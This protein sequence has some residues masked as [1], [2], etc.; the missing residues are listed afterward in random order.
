VSTGFTAGA[1]Y[2]ALL[3]GT[4]L[5][6]VTGVCVAAASGLA[7]RLERLIATLV[8][9]VAQIVGTLLFAGV[10]LRSLS[11]GTVL[12]VNLIVTA[13]AVALAAR[14]RDFASSF[15]SDWTAVRQPTRRGWRR[16][17]RRNVWAWVLAVVVGVESAYL[18]LVVYVMPSASWDSLTYHLPA[19]A[20]WLQ[21]DRILVTP[22]I[23]L[24]NVYPMNGELGF[25]WV[26]SLTRSD[27]LIDGVPFVF[28]VIGAVAVAA[29]ARSVG[30]S[31]P[32]SFVAASLYLLTPLVL[33][34]ATTNYVDLVL[35]GLYLAGYALLLR[36]LIAE[37]HGITGAP[38]SSDAR[39]A[40]LV[41]AGIALGLAAG[42]KST[43]AMYAAIAVLV[44]LANA[45]WW[46]RRNGLPWRACL[47]RLGVFALPIIAFGSFWYVRTWIEY[48]NPTYPFRVELAGVTVFDGRSP[49]DE[50][51]PPADIA[52]YPPAVR[53]LASWSHISSEYFY[54]ER[55]DG[56]GPT[57]LFLELPALAVFAAYCALHRRV[58]LFNFVIP[59]VTIFVLTPSNW[60]SRFTVLIV[61]PGAIALAFLV[62]RIRNHTLV[63]GLQ[64]MVLVSVVTGCVITSKRHTVPQAFTAD[65]IASR[66][67]DPPSERTLGKLVLP[68]YA[69]ADKV[70]DKSR[71]GVY[72]WDL[73]GY[74]VYA[75]F[76]TDFHNEVI[77]LAP[78]ALTASSLVRTLDKSRIDYFVT[79]RES[80]SDLVA[81]A[82]TR[83]LDLVSDV[84]DV[85]VYRVRRS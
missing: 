63:L 51:P 69:W 61:A 16:V 72:A 15:R 42:S 30:V 75:L 31:R 45:V 85:R 39:L 56:F 23:I 33:A 10:A 22:L 49:S 57:W 37:S 24:A 76:G 52:E 9:A 84:R 14:S 18:A 54:D 35:P 12:A 20:A 59:F 38:G 43:G 77:G 2:L 74:F 4:L 8:L 3:A 13:V 32:G 80:P 79:R 62:E 46:R 34:Q 64:A 68:E 48:G 78:E 65:E 44:L 19:V 60:W 41:L 7:S 66:A 25:L 21:G 40:E 17:S 53:S 47:V 5:T 81:R 83:E 55:H 50:N 26:G 67:F 36:Y 27:L 6:L 71:V 58:V 29:L 73:P 28:A 11:T 1:H 70:A 82:H